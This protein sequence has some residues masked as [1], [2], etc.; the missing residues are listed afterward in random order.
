MID[1]HG[2]SLQNTFGSFP[3]IQPDILHACWNVRGKISDSIW[4]IHI[5][6]ASTFEISFFLLLVFDADTHFQM[7]FEMIEDHNSIKITI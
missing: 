2:L 7:T 4:L 1:C 6:I 5:R 3:A